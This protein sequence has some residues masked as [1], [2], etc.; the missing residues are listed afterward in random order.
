MSQIGKG[1]TGQMKTTGALRKFL[2]ENN[3]ELIEEKTSKA[4]E[5]FNRLLKQG[6]NVAAGFHLSC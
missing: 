6:D 3:I 5:T 4:V 2:E 1:S